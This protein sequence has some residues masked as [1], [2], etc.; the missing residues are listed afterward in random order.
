MSINRTNQVHNDLQITT[1]QTLLNVQLFLPNPRSST[2]GF[3][4]P[5]LAPDK[6]TSD[7]P[8]SSEGVTQREGISEGS[9][10]SEGT[11]EKGTIAPN[12]SGLWRSPRSNKGQYE[13]T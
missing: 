4:H 6:S 12:T 1:T 11:G 7:Q 8:R 3:G 5:P 13:S 9:A 10:L 2:E